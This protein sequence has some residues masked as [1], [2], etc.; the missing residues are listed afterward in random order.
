MRRCRSAVP[1]R[2]RREADSRRGSG[3]WMRR[4]RSAVWR[5]DLPVAWQR[6]YESP[7]TSSTNPQPSIR[8]E[9]LAGPLAF[10]AGVHGNLAALDAVLGAC[11][12]AGV[13]AYFVAGNLVFKGDEPLAV[14]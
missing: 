14:W 4:C 1:R 10:L 2:L 7:V 8:V 6:R 11:R 5:A 12:D 9:R 3:G 13:S